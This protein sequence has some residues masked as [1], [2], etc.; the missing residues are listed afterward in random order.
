[1][2]SSRKGTPDIAETRL[3][4]CSEFKRSIAELKQAGRDALSLLANLIS[5]GLL[6]K[7]Q[8]AFEISGDGN[9]CASSAANALEK[10]SG[11][12]T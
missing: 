2:T 1:M 11:I 10:N 8:P 3:R 7:N 4:V 12:A 9:F 5:I 6:Y